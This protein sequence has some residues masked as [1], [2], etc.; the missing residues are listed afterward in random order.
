MNWN[1]PNNTIQGLNNVEALIL[2]FLILLTLLN[3]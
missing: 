3:L 1:E 2:T